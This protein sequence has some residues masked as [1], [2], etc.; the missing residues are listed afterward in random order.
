MPSKISIEEAKRLLFKKHGNKIELMGYLRTNSK[1]KFRCLNG[2]IWE[3]R[4][5]S[6]I[7]DGNGCSVCSGKSKFSYEQVKKYIEEQGCEL[8]SRDYKNVI[9][10]LEIKF[11]CGHVRKMSFGNFKNG[12]RC[13]LCSWERMG[14]D[15]RTNV[16]DIIS[17]LDNNGFGLIEIEEYKNQ[18]S[19]NVTYLCKHGHTTTKTVANL[20]SNP[21]CKECSRIY[22]SENF[23]GDKSP[24]WKGGKTDMRDFMDD[25]LTEWK[26]LSMEKSNYCCVVTGDRF[27]HIHHLYSFSSI[28][29]NVLLELGFEDSSKM[30]YDYS[31]EELN[32]ISKKIIEKHWEYPLGVCL[33]K[34]IHMKF[35]SLYGKSN[36]TPE[37]FY[38]FMDKII[39]GEIKIV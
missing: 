39:D 12:R 35:H 17:F 24:N 20:F 28:V 16:S 30:T 22:M 7:Y 5:S 13:R 8:I 4:V 34:D 37:Q 25:K 31:S 38:D 29:E 23:S 14:K 15:K 10:H 11:E 6:V 1:A 26:K 21:R 3:A 18:K 19:T 27:D 33:R 32:I 2:H 36:N 9:S